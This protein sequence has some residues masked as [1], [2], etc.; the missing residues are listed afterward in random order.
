MS[1]RQ[2]DIRCRTRL[3]LTAGVLLGQ[4]LAYL[5]AGLPGLVA[6][7]VVFA[8]YLAARAVLVRRD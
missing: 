3:G 8:V 1:T 2:P 6:A 5:L 4:V 7:S